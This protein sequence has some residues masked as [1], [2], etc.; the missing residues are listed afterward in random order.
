MRKSSLGGLNSGA[1]G[2]WHSILLQHRNIENDRL[3]RVLR[4]AE[5]RGKACNEKLHRQRVKSFQPET[6][7][8]TSY[9]VVLETLLRVEMLPRTIAANSA[10]GVQPRRR[11]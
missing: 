8:Q 7:R 11:L 9:Q 5:K 3:G 1:S 6:E 2:K 10:T 4:F